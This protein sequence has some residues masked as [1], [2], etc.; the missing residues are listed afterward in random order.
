MIRNTYD[1]NE[2]Y[3]CLRLQEYLGDE[4]GPVLLQ[5]FSEKIFFA[6]NC[7]ERRKTNELAHTPTHSRSRSRT[8]L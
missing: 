8:H 7:S 1:G 5:G 3:V 4:I 2:Q 6:I